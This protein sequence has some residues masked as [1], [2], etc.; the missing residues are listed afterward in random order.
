M[1]E[2]EYA[3][4]LKEKFAPM[5][6]MIVTLQKSDRIMKDFVNQQKILGDKFW[7]ESAQ[8]MIEGYKSQLLQL[9]VMIEDV[10]EYVLNDG[11]PMNHAKTDLLN[12]LNSGLSIYC[13]EYKRNKSVMDEVRK[14]N[15]INLQDNEGT[16]CSLQGL[17]EA[18]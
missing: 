13:S 4:L 1:T 3:V 12:S 5:G 6:E 16:G 9:I 2:K 7:G 11:E 14:L 15:R 8:L 18:N 10:K 17:R